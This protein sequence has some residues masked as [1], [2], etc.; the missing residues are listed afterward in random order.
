MIAL[1]VML[2]DL[3]VMFVVAVLEMVC[4]VASPAL[5]I[6]AAVVFDDVQVTESVK[7]TVFPLWR[8]PVAVNWAVCPEEID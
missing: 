7:S 8:M 2:P 3:A 6:V 4:A 1:L 5:S